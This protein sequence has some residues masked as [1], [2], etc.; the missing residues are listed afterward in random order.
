MTSKECETQLKEWSD[1]DVLVSTVV[2]NILKLMDKFA[3][4]K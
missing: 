2:N 1:K 3:E 4:E